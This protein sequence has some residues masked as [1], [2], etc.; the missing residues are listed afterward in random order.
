ML[1]VKEY[2]IG[3]VSSLNKFYSSYIT[4][5]LLELLTGPFLHT[6]FLSIYSH[7]HYFSRIKTTHFLYNKEWNLMRKN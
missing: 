4:R 5:T 2:L 6:V 7:M 1:F 3:N